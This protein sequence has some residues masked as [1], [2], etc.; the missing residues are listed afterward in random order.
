QPGGRN[1][2]DPAVG[3]ADEERLVAGVYDTRLLAHRVE[4]AVDHRDHN[5]AGRLLDEDM[6]GPLHHRRGALG[7]PVKPSA[8]KFE[9]RYGGGGGDPWAGH[10]REL[11]GTDAVVRVL[12]DAPVIAADF[13]GGEHAARHV[14][15]RDLRD[16]AG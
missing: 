4:P 16:A 1:I 11:E 6:V 7:A 13:P 8:G 2:L 14:E 15:A 5:L 3:A 9:C 10:T 12:L